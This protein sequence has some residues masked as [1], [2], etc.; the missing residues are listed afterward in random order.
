MGLTTSGPNWWRKYWRKKR[1]ADQYFR[2]M[3][4][5]RTEAREHGHGAGAAGSGPDW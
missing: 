3:A 1:A 5:L 4:N 2:Y